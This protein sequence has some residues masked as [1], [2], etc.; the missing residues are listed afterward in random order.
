MSNHHL[1]M[2]SI[3]RQPSFADAEGNFLLHALNVSSEQAAA[4]S[5]DEELVIALSAAVQRLRHHGVLSRDGA[6]FGIHILDSGTFILRMT[7]V[8]TSSRQHIECLIELL[9]S[10]DGQGNPP[11]GGL[12]SA[13]ASSTT[14]GGPPPPLL[15]P[16]V[17]TRRVRP[18]A[19]S[20]THATASSVIP[21]PT[22]VF[23]DT[24]SDEPSRTQ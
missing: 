24:C 17:N 15:T 9:R 16:D 7:D 2:S 22:G 12:P 3:E 4:I 11:G 8:R 5:D 19:A 21:A 6:E 10:G 14:G 23:G 1:T 13:E 20:S 18:R